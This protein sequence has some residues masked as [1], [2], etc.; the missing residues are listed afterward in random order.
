M[1]LQ[2]QGRHAILTEAILTEPDPPF[3]S[4]EVEAAFAAF[5][6]DART[7]LLALRRLI[8]ETAA[9][10]QGIGRIKECLKWGQP[11]YLTPDTKS[12]TTIRLGMPKTGGMALFTHCQTSVISDFRTLFPDDFAYDGNRAVHI[13][14]DADKS[15]LRLI[16]RQALTY[17]QRPK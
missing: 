2:A 11:S 1:A 9:E 14:P 6:E 7:G 17:H 4:P 12:G 16:I 5:P 10:T 3:Q 15:K 13:A 8:F